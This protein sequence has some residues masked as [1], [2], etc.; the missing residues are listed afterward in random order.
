MKKIMMLG[1]A[2]S[3][4]HGSEAIIR[5]TKKILNDYNINL[6]IIVETKEPEEDLKY[7]TIENNEYIRYHEN[8]F[9]ELF[10]KLSNKL[11]KRPTNAYKI[12]SKKMFDDID[13]QTLCMVI[14]GDT[15]CYRPPYRM[16]YYNKRAREKGART[17]LWG[18][19]I[20]EEK[21]TKEMEEDLKRY[22]MIS[23]R[24]TISYE[25]LKKHGIYENVV[26]HPDPA[27][28][29]DKK[30][31]EL[32]LNFK[33]GNTIGINISPMIISYEKE[34]GQTFLNYVELIKH[35]LNTTDSNIALI[36]HVVWE[37]T[38][39][40]KVLK[41]LFDKF[42]DTNRIVLLGDY[43]SV[44]LKGFISRCRMFIG[45]RT[46]A[47]IAAYSTNV[48]TLVIG[49]SVKAKGI[50]RDLFGTYDNYVI[51][52]QTLKNKEDLINAFEWL[53]KNEEEMRKHLEKIMPE[54]K[55]KAKE[56]GE[57]ILKLIK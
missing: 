37:H 35:I 27:F 9:I 51:P 36:P 43:N 46:H 42:K 40:R 15:Y 16:Y 31:L 28:Q 6:P 8:Q 26:L 34:K 4:N 13:E 55:E 47:T 7:G 20:S 18:C 53:R 50:A 39:D 41:E 24:E 2:G 22:N 17:I 54:Y 32:P 3:G 57:E 5:G 45:A 29:L 25:S 38:D 1:H 44:E 11:I 30:E 33:L 56:A 21:I 12:I 10:N 48:P 19:S 49:Y 52:V 14:G 23:V